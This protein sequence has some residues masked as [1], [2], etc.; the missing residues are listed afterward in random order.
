M[1]SRPRTQVFLVRHGETDWNASGRWQGRTDV[2]LMRA[3]CACR[4]A[5]SS[6]GRMRRF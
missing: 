5:P 2:P 3:I 1:A 4:S 6:A